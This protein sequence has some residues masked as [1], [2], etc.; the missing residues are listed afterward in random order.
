MA[1]DITLSNT[2]SSEPATAEDSHAEICG[3]RSNCE[4]W[5]QQTWSARAAKASI[6]QAVVGGA[7]DFMLFQRMDAN[8]TKIIRM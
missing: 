6:Y 2:G 5:N 4:I 7:E 1:D 3:L 8:L